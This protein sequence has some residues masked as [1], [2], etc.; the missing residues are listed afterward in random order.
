MEEEKDNLNLMDFE[1][2]YVNF[3]NQHLELESE[4]KEIY[5][6]L[7]K[8]ESCSSVRLSDVNLNEVDEEYVD[9][10]LDDLDNVD[11]SKSFTKN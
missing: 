8:K 10:C 3:Y 11:A 7:N 5:N 4:K 6:D 9:D 2:D 1:N